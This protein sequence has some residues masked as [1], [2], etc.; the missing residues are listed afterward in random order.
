MKRLFSLLL[1]FLLSSIC[2]YLQSLHLTETPQWVNL[3]DLDISG[4]LITV[5][6]KVTL[7]RNSPLL[8]LNIVSKHTNPTNVNYLLRP[9]QFEINSGGQY[10]IANVPLSSLPLNMPY[11]IAGVYDGGIV[12]LYINGCLVASEEATGNL[13][14]NNLNTAIGQMSSGDYDEQFYGYI[15][16]IRIWNVARTED[17]IRENMN[18]LPNPTQQAGL[19]AY[20][21]F[22]NPNPYKNLQGNPTWDCRTQQAM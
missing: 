16:G 2:I 22:D 7:S 12:K 19:V 4:N 15:D 20:Y 13:V 17:E 18:D 10:H 14:S 6:A 9:A 8:G 3:G 1:L 5:E 11:H 21:K